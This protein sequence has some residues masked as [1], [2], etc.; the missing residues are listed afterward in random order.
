LRAES[1]VKCIEPV[2]AELSEFIEIE[3]APVGKC[4]LAG[5]TSSPGQAGGAD[6]VMRSAKRAPERCLQ[7]AAGTA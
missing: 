7:A 2:A 4:H 3:D 6:R 1:A 5:V